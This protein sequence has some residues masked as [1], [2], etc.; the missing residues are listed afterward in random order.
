LRSHCIV[1]LIVALNLPLNM[2]V[3][4]DNGDTGHNIMYEVLN[5]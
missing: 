2:I 4:P 3:I 1:N 5:N